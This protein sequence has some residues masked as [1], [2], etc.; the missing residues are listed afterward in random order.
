MLRSKLTAGATTVA[1]A[2]AL[3]FLPAALAV[4]PGA[5]A[6]AAT[7]ATAARPA[8]APTSL[9]VTGT[10]AD[11][12]TFTGEI[13]NLTAQVVDRALVLT[14][15][16]TGTGLPTG[17]TTFATPLQVTAQQVC[18][19]L[20]LDLGPL[21]LDLLGL[22]IDLDPVVLDITAV[23]GAGNLLGNLLCAITGLLDN[24]GGV[25]GV[26]NGIANLLNRLLTGLG[27]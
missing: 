26:L 23:P 13:S 21:H 7:V 3:G 2:A 1:L 11:G 24:N 10:L 22:V 25:G 20:S 9:P 6:P 15:T 19:I 27:L 5:A 16:I 17:G 14:G 18:D 4:A 12:T 8:P